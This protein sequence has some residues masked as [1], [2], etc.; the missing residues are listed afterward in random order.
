MVR[1]VRLVG[2]A[3]PGVNDA[4]GG[5]VDT[6]VAVVLGVTK[7]IDVGTNPT[8]SWDASRTLASTVVTETRPTTIP[9]T[10]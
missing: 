8:D 3:T 2:E 10:S 4:E 6:R 9:P 7:A 1:D 5:R